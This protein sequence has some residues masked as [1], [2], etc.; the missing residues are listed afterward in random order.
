MKTGITIYRVIIVVLLLS[1]SIGCFSCQDPDPKEDND[2]PSRWSPYGMEDKAILKLRLF[3]DQLYA[4]TKVRG[5][6][7]RNIVDEFS[8]W[9]YLGFEDTVS[10]WRYAHG[11]YDV[12]INTE[13][14][15]SIMIAVYEAD[16]LNSS[17]LVSQDNGVTWLSSDSGMVYEREDSLYQGSVGEITGVGN[18]IY[19][20][21]SDGIYVTYDFG[22]SWH[23]LIYYDSISYW[24]LKVHPYND[25]ILWVIFMGVWGDSNISKSSDGGLSWEGL[26]ESFASL[27]QFADDIALHPLDEQIV[28]VSVPSNVY[29]TEDFGETWVQ[30]LSG[31]SLG[32]SFSLIS[33]DEKQPNHLVV[34]GRENINFHPIQETF[35]GGVSWIKIDYPYDYLI[36]SHP[37]VD[38]NNEAL[39]LPTEGGVLKYLYNVNLNE[40]E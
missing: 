1:L 20:T 10:D 7:R 23:L 25:H 13:N 15:T 40:G 30:I 31:D 33:I 16:S 28:Y 32:Y 14:P 39:Y 37:L 4:I 29:K 6:Y 38:P 8:E 27:Y 11:V 12:Y 19:G 21:G 9:Q 26:P 24:G 5:L 18:I 3:D 17:I 34:M 22:V 2:E 35:D 36:Y